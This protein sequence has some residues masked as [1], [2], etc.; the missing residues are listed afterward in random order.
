MGESENRLGFF[1]H[2]LLSLAMIYVWTESEM[3]NHSL[4]VNETDAMSFAEHGI[5]G[6]G[7]GYGGFVFLLHVM[8]KVFGEADMIFRGFSLLCSVITMNMI[9]RIGEF[10]QDRKAG[11]LGSF[12]FLW[13][14]YSIEFG[15]QVRDYSVHSLILIL[16]AY[17]CIRILDESDLSP[18]RQKLGLSPML[19]SLG[20]WFVSDHWFCLFFLV[21]LFMGFIFADSH[22]KTWKSA[23]GQLPL[24]ILPPMITLIGLLIFE[25]IGIIEAIGN[26]LRGEHHLGG[27]SVPLVTMEPEIFLKIVSSY[28]LVVSSIFIFSFTIGVFW[29]SSDHERKPHRMFGVLSITTLMM[30]V[31]LA[32]GQFYLHGLIVERYFYFWFPVTSIISGITFSKA[33]EKVIQFGDNAFEGLSITPYL[34]IVLIGFS[35]EIDPNTEPYGDMRG[36]FE[37][38]EAEVG[39]SSFSII[40][41]PPEHVLRYYVRQFEMSP[42]MIIGAWHESELES[43]DILH[44]DSEIVVVI[45]LQS[46][47]ILEYSSTLL[48]DSGYTRDE[49][50]TFRNSGDTIWIW[51]R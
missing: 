16:I 23:F 31:L 39:D 27:G 18:Q 14:G 33:S 44:I 8:W 43:E 5:S 1:D 20:I 22:Q 40:T 3:W 50:A 48:E 41:R 47:W 46:G 2:T 36:G 34:L 35:A 30:W 12:I 10:L 21:F 7:Y 13:S 28:S 6:F 19:I 29:L 37:M 25:L 15:M 51:R 11:L 24:R 38:I 32:V 45:S 42:D 17:W 49:D 26:S 9:Y 4:W